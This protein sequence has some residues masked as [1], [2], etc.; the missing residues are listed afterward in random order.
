[1]AIFS[2]LAG[3]FK[4]NKRRIFITSAVTISVY[5][6]VNEFVIK[7]FKN[8]Q[9][10]LRQE[11]MFK[12]QIKQR[13]LQTQQDCYYTILALL[14]VLATP[15]VESLPV[16]FITQALRLKK[17]QP[18]QPQPQI[19]SG[20]SSEL[21]ADNL[22][23]LDN[24]N[25]PQSKLS[26]YM[27]KSKLELWN[28]LKIKTITRTLTLIYSISGLLLI[29]RLQLNVLA[30][31]S[32][33]ESAILMAGVKA[34]NNDSDPH[35]NYMIEQSYLSLSWWLLNKGWFN[36]SS[37][38][39]N[40]V[41]K[42]FEKITPKTELSVIEF[43]ILLNDII[44]EINTN[45]KELI[46]SNLFP[47]NYQD[48]LDTIVNTNPDLIHYLDIPD[49]NLIKLINETNNIMLDGNLYF[50]D[51][52]NSLILTNL[53][54][55]SSNLSLNLSNVSNSLVMSGNLPDQKGDNQINSKS[56]DNNN[57]TTLS[58]SKI[59]EIPDKSYKLA[60]F[61]AQLSIQNGI[62]INNNEPPQEEQ[63]QDEFE[64][65]MNN[66]N[67]FSG[68][69]IESETFQQSNNDLNGNVYINNMNNLDDLDDFSAGIYSNFE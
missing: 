64:N 59:V 36:L 60:S 3:F 47:I 40:I 34:I 25:N 35:E 7:K 28:L 4:R 9:N 31:R 20:S 5:L 54:T 6:L 65:L 27:N 18:Q 46:L 52:L 14:P 13:F 2:S 19:T 8:Y 37:L 10:A 66:L 30:R 12:Q 63:E 38:I 11:L 22:N 33:L 26:I 15:I 61:L 49:S 43:E 45:N 23:L 51:I 57:I 62:M 32:Y 48:L 55:L 50:F 17:G 1:M 56:Q 16:E 21:T 41:I 44:S 39:E 67:N 53:S 68:N 24:N 29:T 69:A 42:K 58:T